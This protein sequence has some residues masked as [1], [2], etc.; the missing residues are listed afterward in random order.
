[1]LAN[2][3]G[4]KLDGHPTEQAVVTLARPFGIGQH[5]EQAA[6]NAFEED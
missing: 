2:T 5:L 4:K 6:A 1:M 3:L